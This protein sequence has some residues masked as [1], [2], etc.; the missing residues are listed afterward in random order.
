MTAECFRWCHVRH[1]NPQSKNPHRIKKTDLVKARELDYEGI[2]FP[3]AVKD[4]KKVEEMNNININVFGYE[5]KQP[6]PIYISKGE[7]E[8]NM[9]L[10]LITDESGTG[11]GGHYVYIKDF[12]RF[13]YNQ[14][15]Y[16][17]RKHFCRCCLQCFT[18]LD[19]LGRHGDNCMAVNG[20]QAIQMPDETDNTLKFIN[21]HKQLDVPFVI[22]ADFEAITEKVQTVSPNNIKSFT[23]AYQNHVDCGYGF[24]VVCCDGKYS[25]PIET[26]RGKD[27]V[28]KFIKRMLEEVKYCKKIKKEKFNEDM[29][30]TRADIEDFKLAIRCHICGVDYT[31]G[32]IRVRDHCHIT[33]NY[34]GSTHRECNINHRLTDKIPVIF[35]NLRGYD[36]HFIMQE[37]GKF[38]LDINVIPNNMEKYLAFMLGKNL[39]FIDSFQFMGSGLASLARNL[40][41]DRFKY[42][43]E[44]FK[45]RE[46]ELVTK[47]GIYPYDYMDSFDRFDEVALPP[48]DSF[49]SILADEHVS[50][51]EYQH[52]QNVWD[53][54]DLKT[55]GQYHD[56][57]LKTDVLLLADVFENFRKTCLQHY[58]L[59]PC[60]YYTSPGLAWDAML[61]MTGIEL[62]LMTD[63]D[64]FQFIE[65]G[66]RGGVSCIT[67]RFG[68]A[69]NK[70]VRNYN[71]NEPSK[72]IMYLDANNLYGWAMCQRLPTGGFKWL[73]IDSLS[74]D[75]YDEDSDRGVILEVD[76]E[77]PTELHDSHNDY[78]LAPEKM[79][80]DE[81][82]LSNYCKWMQNKHGISVGLVSKLVP[83]LCDKERYVVHYKNLKLYVDLGLKVKKIHRV[84]EF[85]Q[86]QWLG[87][88]IDFNTV[89]RTAAK[90]D[91][92][93]DFFKLMNN[94]V[95]GKTMENLRKRVDVRLVT[96]DKALK[97]LTSKPTFVS[98]KIF[99]EHLVAVHKIKET[100]TLN[101]PAYVGMCILDLSKTLMYDFHYN[102]IMHMY[103]DRVRLL[104]TDTD[105]LMYEIETD[106][107][108]ED[109][110]KDKDK[111]DLSAYDTKSPYFDK[112]NKKVIGKMKDETAG[113][114]IVEF[115]G[116]RSK[117][118]SYIKDDG[119]GGGG[120]WEDRK[121]CY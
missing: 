80:V 27:A 99:N 64:M 62:E 105:S 97:K 20:I 101:R 110:S 121:G 89:K 25:K 65:K 114:P 30:M 50:E 31:E 33:G 51:E 118:Y 74:L 115:V 88:Y 42:T 28:N 69:N 83:N 93:K 19:I 3:V 119:G 94:S 60:H 16:E 68:Q 116:L 57:Y 13:M 78:P 120:G 47:K 104:F 41:K 1:I 90:N 14:T 75:Q 17:H 46:L 112:T 52:A 8:D 35:H 113:V 79:R 34:R 117:M 45:G 87:Q 102:Y 10:L 7:K 59:D 77:Y 82:M 48:K 21:F 53:A 56:L 72:Y 108:Y 23:E 58:K 100:L 61:K 4:Y 15:K 84:L 24:K 29:I 55:M 92:E 91:F 2:E 106:D 76:L 22:Y 44:E 37:I 6:F 5:N 63:V 111:F 39:V 109:F 54:F 38:K 103:G 81:G 85:D 26:Y 70:Y 43:S 71:E 12:N 49:Y 40:P 95:F 98:C 11:G 36:S 66:M 18:T 107:V 67:H 32:D 9:D 96:N 86:S 73:E